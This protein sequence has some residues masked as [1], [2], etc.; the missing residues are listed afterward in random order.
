VTAKQRT[1]GDAQLQE[2]NLIDHWFGS[3]GFARADVRLGIGDDAAIT[4]LQP[5]EQLVTA[6]DMLVEGTHF[7]PAA[8]ARSLG[9]RCLACNL[10]DLAAMGAT[11]RWASLALCLPAFDAAWLDEFALGFF[12]LAEQ[13]EVALIGGDTVRGPLS[14]TVTLQGAIASADYLS[15]GGAQPG[16]KIYV[17]GTPGAAAAGRL[18]LVSEPHAQLAKAFLF[19]EPRVVLGQSLRQLASAAIDISDGLHADLGHLLTASGCG[20][21][22][23][24]DALPLAEM[25]A[26][27]LTAVQAQEY[28]LCGGEDYELLFTVA[29]ARVAALSALADEHGVA[30]SCIGEVNAGDQQ[31]WYQAG[32][33]Y[34]VPDAGFRHF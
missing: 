8:P 19:P 16:D 29:P 24:L 17:S 7:L 13:Y 6:T 28:A 25:L 9:H 26:T 12:K 31:R 33:I 27:G 15:R 4:Q 18:A 21:E 20:A 1:D 32:K 22:L 2:F 11:P 14:M 23:Q 34:T 3:R 5:H 30:L 10:S